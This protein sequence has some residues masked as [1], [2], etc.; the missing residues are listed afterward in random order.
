MEYYMAIKVKEL[1]ATYNMVEFHGHIEWKQQ[2]QKNITSLLNFHKF[3]IKHNLT[4]ATEVEQWFLWWV[5][6]D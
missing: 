3:K 1:L 5:G 6:T 4:I 2:I